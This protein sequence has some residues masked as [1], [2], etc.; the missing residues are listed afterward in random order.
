MAPRFSILLPTRDRPELLRLAIRS[1]LASTAPDFELLVVGDGASR[2][3]AAVVASFS[4]ARIK[5]FDLPKAPHMGYANR[6]VALRQAAGEF[7][8]FAAM[9]IWC[10]PIISPA[11]P[12]RSKTPAPSGLTTVRSG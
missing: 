3:T 5:W 2:D 7:I 8:A 9:M 10:F 4:D 1:V 12:E 11:S 6:N